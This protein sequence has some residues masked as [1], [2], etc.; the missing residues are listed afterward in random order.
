MAAMSQQQFWSIFEDDVP[1]TMRC[2]G[3]VTTRKRGR[4]GA[5]Q[6]E[7]TVQCTK[8]VNRAEK[9][10]RY[11]ANC[12]VPSAYA[13]YDAHAGESFHYPELVLEILLRTSPHELVYVRED[14]TLRPFADYALAK[15]G[16]DA[17]YLIRT[18][19]GAVHNLDRLA[20]MMEQARQA[21]RAEEAAMEGE[22]G[23]LLR[24]WN[25]P[26]PVTDPPYPSEGSRIPAARGPIAAAIEENRLDALEYILA[27]DDDYDY[28]TLGMYHVEMIGSRG[29]VTMLNF[30][31]DHFQD[32]PSGR[33]RVLDAAARGASTTGQA[34]LLRF[35]YANGWRPSDELIF[36][37]VINAGINN[38][39]GA[40]AV[41]VDG[42]HRYNPRVVSGYNMN[43][44]YNLRNYTPAMEWLHAGDDTEQYPCMGACEYALRIAAAQQEE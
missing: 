18:W 12:L 8:M 33:A 15:Q 41:L 35:L 32:Y 16:Y 37:L 1:A 39:T 38:Q 23:I 34:D 4:N 40:M 9:T 42:L 11:C 28:E 19:N 3:R 27:Q 24:R 30:S 26:R 31:I 5:V 10:G 21:R 25:A 36:E 17:E 43:I 14:P 44:C 2:L 13:A 7:R 22:G 29:N 20:A 6:S